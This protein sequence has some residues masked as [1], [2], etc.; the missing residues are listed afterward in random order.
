MGRHVESPAH[1]HGVLA[2]NFAC[3]A[4]EIQGID[5]DC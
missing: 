4:T 2:R 1:F 5:V 3:I